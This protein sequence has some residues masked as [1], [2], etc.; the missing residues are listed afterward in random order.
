[1]IRAVFAAGHPHPRVLTAT[2]WAVIGSALLIAEPARSGGVTAQPKIGEPLLGLTSEQLDRF[3]LG[4][5]AYG[6]T[7]PEDQGLGPIFN[8][9]SCGNCH[10]NPL[11]GPG[12]QKVTRF[13]ATGPDGFDPLEEYGGS[14]FQQA[15]IDPDCAEELPPPEIAD[16][17]EFR[18]TKGMLG[19][20]LVEAIVDE[21]ILAHEGGP[22]RGHAHRVN[23]FED[24]DADPIRVGRFGWKAQLPTVLSFSADA[25]LNEMGLTNRFISQEN[26]PNGDFP[27]DLEDC[28][29]VPDAPYEDNLSMGNGVDKEFID[30][31]TDF[32]RLLA[33]PPQTPR[34]GMAGETIFLNVGCGDCH[35]PQY[36]TRDDPA[37]EDAIRNKVIR[38]Y[39]DFLL[40]DMGAVGDPIVQGQALAGEVKTPPLWG[41]RKR[42]RLLH[43]GDANDFTFSGRVAQVIT[44]HSDS[45][46]DAADSASAYNALNPEEQ[47]AVLRFLG[48]LGRA[49]FDADDDN[50][51][52][53]DD[54][55]GFFDTIGF[56]PCFGSTPTPEDDCAIHDVDQDTDV[57][58]DDF[59]VMMTVYTG[60][61]RDCNGNGI[62]DL[63]DILD[64]TETDDDND[65]IPDGCEPTCPGDLD[66]SGDVGIADLLS[67]LDDWGPCPEAP[68]PC[69]ADV[70]PDLDGRVGLRDLLTL[71]AAWGPC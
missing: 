16:V 68:A 6:R 25:A 60:P 65:G 18:V 50:D 42:P 8:K 26:D 64:G 41:I 67:L 28:D 15:A 3:L 53:L 63:R 12:T 5:A 9:E 59:D 36:S 45:L 38:P 32:Q 58:F 39:S 31:V 4:R 54:F 61:R 19:Y 48:S 17:V 13:G 1:M 47:E 14:L 33:P 44:Q 35:V 71:L 29:P 23:P 56:A 37:L 20:G 24:P 21:D 43:D 11:G 34:S 51:V 7:L 70:D 22:G 69:N 57:D 62:V 2:T 55:H 10:N 30:V 49:E 52:E 40:H 27:P 46:S 66:G